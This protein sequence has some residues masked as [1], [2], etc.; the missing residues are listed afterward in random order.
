MLLLILTHTHTLH[1]LISG[2]AVEPIP[3]HNDNTMPRDDIFQLAQQDNDGHSAN[4]DDDDATQ[5]RRT[6]TMYRTGFIVDD[7]PYR[8]LD[9]A[10]N[11]DFLRSLAMGRTPREFLAS[12]E[13]NVTV[14]LVDKRNQD[15]VETFRS[16]SGAGTS[17]GGEHTSTT[18]T[19]GI[20]D[21][22]TLTSL[23][24]Q[25]QQE[26][27]TN[28]TSIQVKLL[29]G[30]RKVVKIQ[31][32]ATV[33]TLASMLVEDALQ[34][35]FRLVTGFPPRPLTDMNATIQESGLNGAQV[36]MKKV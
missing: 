13:G 6:I 35:Q 30:T 11:A 17:L 5:Q 2:L 34:Q 24:T 19:D 31:L 27:T 26:D 28:T 1:S 18:N 29:N 21:P 15:Y 22:S 16:F 9:D 4:H 23:P 10:D 3:H 32:S 20:I 36:M 25:E 12:Q 7:G 14:N 8:R 33:G